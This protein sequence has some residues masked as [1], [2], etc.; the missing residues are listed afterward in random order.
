VSSDAASVLGGA[1]LRRIDHVDDRVRVT[2]TS[3]RTVVFSAALRGDEC[4]LQT[5]VGPAAPPDG[6]ELMADAEGRTIVRVQAR[7]EEVS[8]HLDD[9]EIFHI[10][11]VVNEDGCRVATREERE[12]GRGL[13]SV[14]DRLLGR[15]SSGNE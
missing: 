5:K 4:V 10:L 2:A 6:Y 7:G 13:T 3:G 14:L 8:L 1:K 11:A 15:V 9:G 12:H